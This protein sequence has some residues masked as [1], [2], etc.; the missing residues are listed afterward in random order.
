MKKQKGYF[1]CM[2][3]YDSSIPDRMRIRQQKSGKAP[4][5]AEEQGIQRLPQKQKAARQDLEEYAD[6]YVETAVRHDVSAFS[7]LW[8]GLTIWNGTKKEAGKNRCYCGGISNKGTSEND[9]YTEVDQ[10]VLSSLG[11]ITMLQTGS[12][13]YLW[14]PGCV[15]DLKPLIDEY[16]PHIKAYLDANPDYESLVT[17]EDGSIMDFWLKGSRKEASFLPSGSFDK[18]GVDVSGIRL[19]MIL[20]K[21]CVLQSFTI[22]MFPTSPLNGRETPLRFQSLFNC[23]SNI[24]AENQRILLQQRGTGYDIHAD[25]AYTMVETMEKWYDRKLINPLNG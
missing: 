16:A 14:C 8:T 7:P 1:H 20:Q 11:T 5:A 25:G 3:L 21:H 17:N 6:G 23:N 2:L 10:M 4:A 24:S 13:Q 9:V 12:G 15:Y 19:W 18:A 22:R